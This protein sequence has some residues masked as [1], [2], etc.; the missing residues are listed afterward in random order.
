MSEAFIGVTPA[1]IGL[2]VLKATI[3]RCVSDRG[4]QF[5]RWP[6]RVELL[7]MKGP[8]KELCKDFDTC[9]EG[10]AFDEN[11]ELRWKR[12][13]E[14]YEVLL[15]SATGG[16]EALSAI[17]QQWQTKAFAARAY[18]HTETRFPRKV[19]IPDNLDLGQRYFI[20]AETAS[21]QFIALRVM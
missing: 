13:G 16:V 5:L 20:D 12:T 1:P 3:E 21:V 4:W 18:P 9:P 15:L 8:L 2:E 11:R 14:G 7:P 17:G 6:H 19:E 10:Q